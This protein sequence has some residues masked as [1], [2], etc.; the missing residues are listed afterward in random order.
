MKKILLAILGFLA[1]LVSYAQAQLTNSGNMQLFSGATLTFFGNFNNNGTLVDSSLSVSFSGTAAQTISGSATTAFNNLIINNANGVTLQRAVSI[2]KTLT[3]TSGKFTLGSNTLTIS[4]SSGT[5]VTSTSGY[6]LSE[7]TDN[8]AK[9][10]WKM[11]TTTGAHV[12]PF[13]NASGVYIPLTFNL[14]AGT[15]GD[16]TVSTYPT[17]LNNTP[18]PSSPIAV[19]HVKNAF[20]LDNS[21]NVVDRFWEIDKSGASGTATIT[22]TATP[23]DIGVIVG[24][25]AQRWNSGTAGWDAA[26]SGQSS[27]LTSATVPNVTS[28]GPWTMS[29][30]GIPLP[31]ELLTFSARPVDNTQVDLSWSTA[32]E[33]SNDYFTI[34]KTK[35]GIH[36]SFVATV[37]GHGSSSS[38]HTYSAIDPDPYTGISYYRLKQTDFNGGYTYTSPVAVN[39]EASSEFS[40]TLYPNPSNGSDLHL[41]LNAE[42]DKTLSLVI[43][44]AL[45]KTWYSEIIAAGKGSNDYVLNPAQ[46]LTPGVYILTLTD[47]ENK[48]VK[49]LVVQ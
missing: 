20:G 30:N 25:T 28:F 15:I 40:L 49:K 4:K 11:N 7:Q 14:T 5:A 44:D 46:Q 1:A 27:T 36:Y 6:I 35:D 31:I 39:I 38:A 10:V 13:G 48:Y 32:T 26:L 18:Y 34:E 43:N 9:V 8:S 21:L 16:V 47:G 41:A 42:E 23:A 33:S 45:G 37:D 29:G 24:L 3:L 22:F 19:T 2:S 12:F 17:A